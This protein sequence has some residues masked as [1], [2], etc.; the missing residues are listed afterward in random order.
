M[1]AYRVHYYNPGHHYDDFDNFDQADEYAKYLSEKN[2]IK[3]VN[4]VK[5]NTDRLYSR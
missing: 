1:I 5:T 3:D 4:I 2:D